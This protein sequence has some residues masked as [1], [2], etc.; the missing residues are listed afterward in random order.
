LSNFLLACF[1]TYVFG[2]FEPIIS[3][4][5]T[6]VACTRYV[7]SWI[8]IFLIAN[9]ACGLDGTTWIAIVAY[10]SWI[11]FNAIVSGCLYITS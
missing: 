6:I 9:G 10:T 3:S 2:L 8:D 11:Y 7:P 5:V 4:A 1:T